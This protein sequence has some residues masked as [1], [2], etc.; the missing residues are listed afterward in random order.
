MILPIWFTLLLV[1]A[2]VVVLLISLKPAAIVCQIQSKRKD[3]GLGWKILFALI[4]LFVLGYFLFAYTVTK[5]EP[6]IVTSIIPWILFGGSVFV[7]LVTSMSLKSIQNIEKIAALER[8]HA[9]HDELTSLPNRTLLYERLKQAIVNARR[10]GSTVSV[11]IMDLNQFKEVND[12]LGHHCGDGLLQQVTPRLTNTL[13][14]SDTVARFG[15]DEFAVILPDTDLVGATTIS[16]KIIN[17]F[18]ESFNV[19]GHKLQIG[20]SIGISVYPDDAADVDTL[21][22]KADVAMYVAKRKNLGYTIYDSRQD[23]H[24]LNRLII[25]G[26]LHDAIKNDEL[27]L[28]YQPILETKGF[29]LWGFEALVRWRQPELGLLMPE[30]FIPIAEQSGLIK[31][32]SRW[33][34]NEALKQI[35]YWQEIDS[36]LKIS[37]NLSVKD[38]QDSSFLN[39][40]NELF[41]TTQVDPR[42]LNIE[43]TES[44]MMT[45]SRRAYEVLYELH[46]IGVTLSI[47][48][49]GT[50]FSSLSYLKQL[51]AKSI[52]IDKSFVIDMLEDDNDAVIVRST[53]DLAHNMGRI[54]IAEGV[55]N[56]ETL[57]ILEIL[58]CDYAQGHYLGQPIAANLVPDWI[59]GDQLQVK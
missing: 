9:L 29:G 13:R 47:D 7:M 35:K 45:D 8:H 11:L 23:R 58:G 40:L 34:L 55:E 28:Y 30:E 52:K 22:Q 38:L 31:E 27:V 12:T 17:A 32:L 39:Y 46:R 2:G 33:S 16:K 49:F 10:Q 36:S 19:E 4:C 14:N 56:K 41:V 26:K 44:I 50:G 24:T 15:G 6:S 53:I 1:I 48:D 42:S 51:P 18:E 59:K 3:F 5:L 37:V 54:V 25:I 57:D 20:I 21:I 43:I